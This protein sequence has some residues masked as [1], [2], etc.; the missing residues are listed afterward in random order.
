MP[1][2]PSLTSPSY[3]RLVRVS[4]RYDLFVAAGFATP[5]TYELV[6]RALTA[7]TETFGLGTHPALTPMEILYANLMGSLIVV[8]SVLR[9]RR[10]SAEYGLYDGASRVLFSL[11]MAYALAGGLPSYLW[12]FLAIEL[13]FGITQLAPWLRAALTRPQTSS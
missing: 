10:P 2:F 3:L 4:A 8:W 12:A 9:I 11:G 13:T 6:H 5:W 1:L 7:L